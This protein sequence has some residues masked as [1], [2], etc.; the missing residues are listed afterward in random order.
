MDTFFELERYT[1]PLPGRVLSEEHFRNYVI[2]WTRYE[3]HDSLW[4]FQDGRL[5]GSIQWTDMLSLDTDH[6]IVLR[7]PLSF[8]GLRFAQWEPE[9]DATPEDY[10]VGLGRLARIYTQANPGDKHTGVMLHGAAVLSMDDTLS[11]CVL[12]IGGREFV[13]FQT[14]EETDRL[15]DVGNSTRCSYWSDFETF[16]EP[17]VQQSMLDLGDYI[18]D[19]LVA[20]LPDDSSVIH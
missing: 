20:L 9:P 13:N 19:F 10:A 7:Y 14:N 4:V 16:R 5:K 12:S 15:I 1:A 6:Q 11:A 3:D 2:K 8:E 17:D 18:L